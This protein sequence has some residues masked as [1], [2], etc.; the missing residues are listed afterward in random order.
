MIAF[1]DL[2]EQ[3]GRQFRTEDISLRVE[4]ARAAQSFPPGGIE[5]RNGE[6]EIQR[7]APVTG[8]DPEIELVRWP[9]DQ[10]ACRCSG[11]SARRNVT[12]PRSMNTG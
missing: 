8:A 12:P 5:E 1:E 4:I 2:K 9:I 6:T 3:I 7:E 11:S 10:I